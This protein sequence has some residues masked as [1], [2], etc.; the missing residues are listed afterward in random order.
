MTT[1][2]A[3]PLAAHLAA[4]V[5]KRLSH[6][7]GNADGVRETESVDAVHD[8]RVASR[9]LRAFLDVFGRTM[10]PEV[11]DAARK[12]LRKLSRAMGPLRDADVLTLALE[13]HRD[14][15]DQDLGKAS[16]DHVLSHLHGIRLEARAEARKK[17]ARLDIS[18]LE[19][20]VGAA[21][22]DVLE[23]VPEDAMKASLYSLSLV[24]PFVAGVEDTAHVAKSRAPEDLHRLRI[25]AKKLRYAVELF[26]PAFG[27]TYRALHKEI[28]AVQETLGNHHD[29][30]VLGAF[31]EERLVVLRAA[32]AS[33]LAAYLER[34]RNALSDE[35]ASAL[36]AFEHLGFD[37]AA[38]RARLETAL[39]GG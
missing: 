32:R 26:Q 3:S 13:V 11:R 2:T 14:R 23:H 31:V 37:A 12:P 5:E 7:R 28:E 16:V 33:T 38:Y 24:S 15:A 19:R 30:H 10:D 27:G 34:Y 6:L 18:E 35:E 4:A 21:L 25:A 20:T 29:A 17:L 9:R 36:S 8:L 22:R 1:E 39:I